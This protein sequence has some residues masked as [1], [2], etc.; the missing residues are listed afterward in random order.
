MKL[1]K[2]ED[3]SKKKRKIMLIS[4]GVIVLICFSFLLYKTFASFSEE[5]SFPMMNG[6]VDYFGN[7]DVYF[8]FYE[9]DK[10]LE[11]MPKK[12]NEENLVFSHGECDN[13]ANIVWDNEEWSPLV[14]NLKSPK[15]RCS[16]YFDKEYQEKEL[17]GAYPVLSKELIPIN[18]DN[19]GKVTKADITESWYEYGNKKWANAIILI[20]ENEK[21]SVGENIPEEKIE[22]YFVWIPRYKYRLKDDEET[23]NSYDGEKESYTVENVGQFYDAIGGN[24]GATNPFEIEFQS[25][26]MDIE[27]GTKA[28]EWLTHPAFTSF[29]SNG[30]WA[31]K[32]E[33][34]TT[35][36]K[37]Y[38]TNEGLNEIIPDT[39][40]IKPDVYPWDFI[41][42][43]HAFYNSYQYKRELD[44]HMM[45]NTEWGAVA[46]LSNS[47]YGRCDGNNCSTIRINNSEITG[48]ASQEEPTCNLIDFN[49]RLECNPYFTGKYWDYF[50][51]KSN[52]ASTTNNY[53][54]IYD[55]S[56]SDLERVMGVMKAS[57]TNS[58]PLSGGSKIY[59]SGFN[60]PY[61]NGEG[62]KTDG[63]PFPDEKYY[64]LYE[65]NDSKE[66]YSEGKLGDA[67]K[68]M[69][70]FY[71]LT[72]NI[73]GNTVTDFV[74]SWYG[75]I[76]Y[77]MTSNTPWIRRGGL[78]SNGNGA[79]ISFF[80][81]D[82]G[83]GNNNASSFRVVLSP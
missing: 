10:L 52:L 11:E 27:N 1:K 78:N 20:D 62:E 60:G 66:K 79:G 41:D 64:D 31:G 44:S 4:F 43:A 2:Y 74:N 75:G 29:N 14:R 63:L 24:K 23:F 8:V 77:F 32:F 50:N 30:F 33:S 70:P 28:T 16:L 7:S 69:G 39:L 40:R 82:Q 22:S 47:K 38:S 12:D 71:R 51:S 45:K 9:G 61:G 72:Y 19:S 34:T 15:T 67:T 25:K 26:D 53:Y 73:D 17:N 65:Y 18:I 68:E 57:A 58:K 59:N 6:Q 48:V 46:Y 83:C 80:Y 42:V 55:L 35:V 56:G 49:I 13:G 76:S 54:G 36:K 21:Y 81:S 3:K 37:Y 5:V